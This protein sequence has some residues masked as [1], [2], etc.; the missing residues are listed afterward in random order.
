MPDMFIPTLLSSR[1]TCLQMK[2]LTQGKE[3]KKYSGY[4]D[5]SISA[6]LGIKTFPIAVYHMR[7][8]WSM[9]F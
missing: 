3:K 1:E 6:D 7:L 4:E 2:N 9:L 8:G 5:K